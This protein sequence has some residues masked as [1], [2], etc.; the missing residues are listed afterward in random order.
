MLLML[1]R[2][3]ASQAIHNG[4]RWIS[5][6]AASTIVVVAGLSRSPDAPQVPIYNWAKTTATHS[7][8]WITMTAVAA[9]ACAA[10]VQKTIGSPEVWDIM[11]ALVDDLRG[12]V[13]PETKYGDDEAHHRVTLFRCRCHRSKWDLV[14]MFKTL[15]KAEP[16]LLVPVVRSGHTGQTTD[17]IFKVSDIEEECRGIAGRAWFKDRVVSV[18][19]LPDL[20]DSPPAQVFEDYANATFDSADRVRHRRPHMR[21]I[22]AMPISRAG[23]PWGVLVFDSRLP[24][25]IEQGEAGILCGV[26]AKHISKLTEKIL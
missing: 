14:G 7:G 3:Q 15:V 2:N 16:S 11:Y 10:W 1:H 19:N 17:C 8:W 22:V 13:F 5:A 9:G 23:A 24:E 4:V 12:Q 21:S 20:H 6:G 26:L 25:K 18:E